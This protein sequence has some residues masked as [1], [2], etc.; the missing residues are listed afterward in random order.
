MGWRPPPPLFSSFHIST[1]SVD[2]QVDEVMKS[3]SVQ[4]PQAV[5][6]IPA[7][8]KRAMKAG[9]STEAVA[10]TAPVPQPAAASSSMETPVVEQA[11]AV[12]GDS[13]M[14]EATATGS[15]ASEAG[16]T[17]SSLMDAATAEGMDGAERRMSD[18]GDSFVYDV[19]VPVHD[20]DAGSADEEMWPWLDAPSVV[21][22]AVPVIAV[23]ENDDEFFWA[24]QLD[25]EAADTE[26][27]DS[28]DSNAESYYANSYPDEESSYANDGVSGGDDEELDEVDPADVG[29]GC[30][31]GTA[32]AMRRRQGSFS[33]E[34]EDGEDGDAED[35]EIFGRRCHGQRVRHAKMLSCYRAAEDDYSEHSSYLSEEEGE[36]REAE[37]R[38]H[39]AMFLR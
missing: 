30:S 35:E 1:M 7:R 38:R 39:R 37:G 16:Q 36:R 10:A 23:A 13:I 21:D 15:S 2:P 33:D 28:E 20:D 27:H 6:R 3:L 11:Q 14:T 17:T 9:P 4:N 24:G 32:L 25:A 19:Y 12:A 5:R 26:E 34:D 29:G 18:D 31:W 8:P 22:L